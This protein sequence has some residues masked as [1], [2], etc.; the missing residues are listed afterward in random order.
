M[1][2]SST[3]AEC[4]VRK[5]VERCIQVEP[6]LKER[7]WTGVKNYVRKTISTL[8]KRVVCRGVQK[9]CMAG[10]CGNKGV[11]SKIISL[12]TEWNKIKEG[13]SEC[14]VKGVS[15]CDRFEAALSRLISVW[16]K[17]GGGGGDITK[18][19]ITI[20]QILYHDNNIYHDIVIFFLLKRFLLNKNL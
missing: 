15:R 1:T 3:H 9:K 13:R 14:K 11:W 20:W 7:T 12:I 5:S 2:T 6:A 8:K 4:L 19:F 17:I 16:H 10:K 18:I